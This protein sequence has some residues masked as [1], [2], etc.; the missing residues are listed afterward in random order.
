MT[1][2]VKLSDTRF[3]PSD[4]V[5]HRYAASVPSGTT[6][7]DILHPEYFGNCLAHMRPGMEISVLSE[8]FELDARLR[9]LTT[10]KTTAKLRV[11]DV[12]AGA[13]V[14][15]DETKMPEVTMAG[16]EVNYGG[17]NHKWRF[18]HNRTVVEHGFVTQGEAQEAAEKYVAQA[19][20]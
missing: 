16:I 15:T 19:N 13:G 9:V 5:I 20:G 17:P 3:T 12:Y 14:E 18:L 8:D 6:L 10:S 7:E 11:L 1:D 4:Y 2:I